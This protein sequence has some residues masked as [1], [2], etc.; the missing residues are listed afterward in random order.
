MAYHCTSVIIYDI[1]ISGIARFL[2]DRQAITVAA[3]D[4]NYLLNFNYL[5]Q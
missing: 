4:R 5:S 2:D 3:P 1:G